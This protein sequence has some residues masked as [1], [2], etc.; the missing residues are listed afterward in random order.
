MSENVKFYNDLA[1]YYHLIL[2][3]WDRAVRWQAEVLD[4][5]IARLAGPGSKRILDAT[6]GIGTQAIG[7]ALKG[8]AMTASDLSHQAVDRT[9]QEAARLGA[10]LELAVADMRELDRQFEGRTFDL[11][12]S[13]DNALP[14]LETDAELERALAAFRSLLEE[15]GLVL[16]SIRN[17]DRLRKERP[18][19][20]APK[21]FRD[22]QEE[23]RVSQVWHWSEDGGT[24]D[25]EIVLEQD[26]ETKV[27]AG[28]YRALTRAEL[29]RALEVS[30]FAG[31]EWLMPADSGYYQPI[32]VAR[33]A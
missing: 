18:E 23:R 5:L 11:V 6:C 9:G 16:A 25:I 14:H 24:C 19:G 4:A 26:G 21:V 3:D 22:G 30:G 33:A 32:V 7:L 1:P 31:V 12:V 15:G 29:S 27:F 28:R 13:L 20:L 8:H 2:E 17:Y 10:E